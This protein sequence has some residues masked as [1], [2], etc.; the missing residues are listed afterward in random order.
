MPS[1]SATVPAAAA[2]A[3]LDAADDDDAATTVPADD[4]AALDAAADA[5]LDDNDVATTSDDAAAAAPA[6]D[7]ADDD[8]AA[9]A[10][11]AADD[12]DAASDDDTTEDSISSWIRT[13]RVSMNGMRLKDAPNSCKQ[14][15]RA[16]RAAVLSEGFAIQYAAPNIQ[17]NIEIAM[18]AVRQNGLVLNHLSEGLRNNFDVVI[19]A[20]RQNGRSLGF[21]SRRL[22]NNV[23]VVMS[24]VQENGLAIYYA[25]DALKFGSMAIKLAAVK[26]NKNAWFSIDHKLDHHDSGEDVIELV[27]EI[28]KQ[29]GLMLQHFYWLNN[30]RTVIA[31]V[32]QNGLA[33]RYATREFRG[34]KD[35][36]LV[37]VT[38]NGLALQFVEK[39]TLTD[40][41]IIEVAVRECGAIALNDS[42]EEYISS[43]DTMCRLVKIDGHCLYWGSPE[44]KA[45]SLV[46]KTAN[47]QIHEAANDQVHEIDGRVGKRKY[48]KT[49]SDDEAAVDDNATDEASD[50]IES[51]Y[52]EYE[53]KV[54]KV[55]HKINAEKRRRILHDKLVEKAVEKA[56]RPIEGMRFMADTRS[57]ANTRSTVNIQTMS[58]NNIWGWLKTCLAW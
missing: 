36:A 29:D 15:L 16:V 37:A 31:A 4:D 55:K 5:V 54:F 28:L 22:C 11:D 3:A 27:V 56:M 21:A 32:S 10:D 13:S 33:L 35:V 43:V 1:P 44:I 49:E 8:N 26:Q 30:L 47:D 19:R 48:D 51:N 12:D 50:K 42:F 53:D 40:D 34:N 9:P 45:N 57:I 6:D 14:S 20:V 39:S 38:Q 58:F 2:A 41:D 18:L 23:E 24:A 25:S 7:A 46:N 52:F 17:E